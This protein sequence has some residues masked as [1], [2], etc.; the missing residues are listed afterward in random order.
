MSH[1]IDYM[2][3]FSRRNSEREEQRKWSWF[4]SELKPGLEAHEAEFV[5]LDAD[6]IIKEAKSQRKVSLSSFN[7][8]S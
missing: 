3:D 6:E 1:H 5:A 4:R 2:R 8:S 7:P